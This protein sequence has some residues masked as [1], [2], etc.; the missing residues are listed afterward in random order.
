[1]LALAAQAATGQRVA[2]I[3]WVLGGDSDLPA[4][5]GL[6]GE[7]ALA[8]ITITNAIHL[9]PHQ[10]VFA[11]ARRLPWPGGGLAVIANGTRAG[12]SPATGHTRCAPAWNSS[13]G[14]RSGPCRGGLAGHRSPRFSPRDG[15]R[16]PGE[17]RTGPP[18][19]DTPAARS[20][21]NLN[22]YYR[23]EA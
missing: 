19:E 11:A 12:T 15:E 18:G 21:K 14:L 3:T 4:L 6:P 17:G 16:H 1:M 23:A 9:M 20:R 5:A 22:H 2:N 10:Q 7:H 13:W 8:A